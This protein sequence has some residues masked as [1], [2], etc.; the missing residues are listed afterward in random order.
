MFPQNVVA[1]LHNSHTAY[2]DF[3]L[4]SLQGS[5]TNLLA[6]WKLKSDVTELYQ[7]IPSRYLQGKMK[8]YT[9]RN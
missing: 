9:L 7:C 2:M 5:G 6:V 8:T 4:Y 1:T 3:T